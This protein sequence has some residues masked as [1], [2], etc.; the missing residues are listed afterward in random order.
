[1]L[2]LLWQKCTYGTSLCNVT[3]S[4]EVTAEPYSLTTR[5]SACLTPSWLSQSHPE[6]IPLHVGLIPLEQADVHMW[7]ARSYLW[8]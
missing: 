8:V 2:P 5:I 3:F 1:M 6:G 7:L 4:G